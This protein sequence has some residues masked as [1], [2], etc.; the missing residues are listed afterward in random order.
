MNFEEEE[1]SD[2]EPPAPS[3]TT[4][5][6]SRGQRTKLRR[7]EHG[8]HRREIH[9][10]VH[11]IH[12]VGPEGNPLSPPTVLAKFSN[13][14]ACIVK[15]KVEITWAE[16]NN[17]PV[18]YKTHIW[19]EVTRS[20]HYPEDADLNKCREWVMH[21]A[22]RAFRNFKSMLT[23]YYLKLGK[24]PC[25]KYTMVKEHHWE[26]FCKQRTTEEAKAK[27][28]K[29]SALAKK[30]LHPHHLGMTGFAG[31][32]PQ[33]RE[34]ER[35]RAAAGLPDPYDGVDLRAKDFIYAR[36]PK[37]LKE[38]ASKFNEPKFEEVER[39]LIKAAKSKDS[40][41][42]CRGQDLLTLAL[43][44]PEHRGRI[45]GMSSKMS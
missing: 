19:G 21:V 45:R 22:G 42:V 8:R 26:E 20:F 35:A 23:R 29:F 10:E 14:V 6:K 30:N 9:G 31:K 41:K 18:D 11:V 38:G 7:G 24:S 3:P 39:A 12:E 1:V 34:E 4:S 33:W 2:K 17:V 28:A 44:T 15:D 25:V 5:G 43:G 32:R 16:W 37:K 36:K 13:Q 40:F 27:S